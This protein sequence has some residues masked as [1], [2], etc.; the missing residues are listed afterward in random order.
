MEKSK[1]TIVLIG[2][3][4]IVIYNFRKELIQRLME[5]GYRVVVMLPC[6]EEAEKIR[7]LGCE[8]ID[9]PV[10]RRGMNPV[11]DVRLF[12]NYKRQ[13]KKLN[14]LLALT[15][16]IKP[17]IYGGYACRCRRIPY[18]A[19]VT[20]IGS[21]FQKKGLLLRIIASMYRIGLKQAACVFFQNESNRQLFEKYRICAKKERLVRGSGVNLENYAFAAYPPDREVHLLYVGRIMRE[22]GIEELLQA[23]EELHGEGI[24]FE[25][26]GYCDENY[27]DKLDE[28]EKKGLIKQLGFHP[29]VREYMK[30]ASAV[31]LPSYH[32][33]MS[34]VL[35]EA[36][37]VGR[38]V[39]ATNISGCREI[40]DEGV[41]GFGCEPG[42]SESLIRALQKFLALSQ[43][44]RAEMGRRAREKMER[45]FDRRLVT[46]VYINEIENILQK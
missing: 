17:N 36:S 11:R 6:V 26:L 37:A 3:H 2:N 40:F 7:A 4:H 19:T 41:T 46:D 39:I 44:E 35:L 9:I 15:Y 13:L 33:G 24:V 1:G 32:E 14:P 27:Q 29:D 18:I 38:P 42:S 43:K 34:N 16:T 22:K 10:D 28:Y 8:L 25:L 12:L 5:E 20:G 23:A 21:S 30:A 45:E 31:V